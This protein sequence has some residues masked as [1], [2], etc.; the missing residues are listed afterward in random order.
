MTPTSEGRP[1]RITPY[2]MAQILHTYWP[3]SRRCDKGALHECPR[4]QR[5]LADLPKMMEEATTLAHA[6]AYPVV[7]GQLGMSDLG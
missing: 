2:Q 6:Q 3:C 4:F 5:F 7:P 1:F